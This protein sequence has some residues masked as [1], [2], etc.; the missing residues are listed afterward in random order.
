MGRVQKDRVGGRPSCNEVDGHA[1]GFWGPEQAE[2]AR[3]VN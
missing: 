2:K 1:R 3:N